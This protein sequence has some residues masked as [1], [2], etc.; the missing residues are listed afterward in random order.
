MLKRTCLVIAGLALLLIGSSAAS[1]QGN[2]G[3]GKGG[4]GK[5]GAVPPGVV[6][7][8]NRGD[9][10]SMKSD[11]KEQ[12][13]LFHNEGFTFEPSHRRHGG[14]RWFLQFRPIAGQTYPDGVTRHELFAIN[15]L[16]QA[17]QLSNDPNLQFFELLRAGEV[18]GT[19]S[20]DRSSPRRTHAGSGSGTIDLPARRQFREARGARKSLW[21]H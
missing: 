13:F 19:S 20:V 2:K 8:Y 11:G 10:Y 21:C 3:G 4:G 18:M 7:V 5:G 16:G 12:T 17:R 14:L 9:V 6:Y 15:E 1:A